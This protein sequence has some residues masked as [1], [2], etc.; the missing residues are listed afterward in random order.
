MSVKSLVVYYSRTG[1]TRFVAEMIAEKLK[2][3][4]EELIDKKGRGGS[5]GFLIAGKDAALKKET[6]MGRSNT[7][8]PATILLSSGYLSGLRRFPLR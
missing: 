1:N 5:I 8:L 2:A 3:D 7:L 4:I 6:Q